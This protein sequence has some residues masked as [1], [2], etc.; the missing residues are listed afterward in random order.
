VIYLRHGALANDRPGAKIFY[1]RNIIHDYPDEQ[2]LLI[3]KNI[4]IA[5]GPDS[6][7][8]IDDMIIPDVNAHWHATQLDICMMTT[9]AAIERTETQW[10]TLIPKA[11]LKINKIYTY[12]T[13]R[14]DSIIE[15]VPI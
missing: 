3:L 7:L 9:L 11:G 14:N 8:L 12:I 2:A 6:V 1:M 13:T 15:C 10:H 5:L 4:K